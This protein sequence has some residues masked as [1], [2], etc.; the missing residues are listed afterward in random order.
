MAKI[1]NEIK[2]ICTGSCH[3][4]ISEGQYKEGLIVCGAKDCNMRG[5]PFKKV[6]RTGAAK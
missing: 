1:S 6:A 5:K 2:Y 4:Q 3:A